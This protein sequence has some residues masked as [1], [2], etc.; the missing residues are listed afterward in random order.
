[1][2]LMSFL[3]TPLPLPSL[4]AFCLRLL[5]DFAER[6]QAP[7]GSRMPIVFFGRSMTWP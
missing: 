5:L 1:M 4:L 2:V 3:L 7:A 6:H